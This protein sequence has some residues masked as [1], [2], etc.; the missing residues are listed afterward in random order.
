MPET[1]PTPCAADPRL[2][3]S[4]HLL[5]HQ[6]AAAGCAACPEATHAFCLDV[7]V[8]ERGTGT[9][10]GRLFRAGV[11]QNRRTA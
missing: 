4:T 2:W 6:E 3:D 1:T 11:Q 8:V 7:A 5:D 10:A 9:Y